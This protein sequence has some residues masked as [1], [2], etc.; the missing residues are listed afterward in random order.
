MG[1]GYH[2]DSRRSIAAAIPGLFPADIE[3][4]FRI[5]VYPFIQF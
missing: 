5:T 2:M 3:N 4:M 1:R